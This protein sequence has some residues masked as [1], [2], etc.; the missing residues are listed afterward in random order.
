MERDD[1]EI[2]HDARNMKRRKYLKYNNKCGYNRKGSPKCS[3]CHPKRNNNTGIID[4]NVFNRIY[5]NTRKNIFIN[6]YIENRKNKKD[7]IHTKIRL[8]TSSYY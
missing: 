7:L 6:C 4:F 3:Y 5:K 2:Y 8:L 1:F